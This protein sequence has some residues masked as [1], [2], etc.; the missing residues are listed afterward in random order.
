VSF[1]A[2]TL[3]VASQQ[4]FIVVS[5]YFVIDLVRKILATHSYILKVSASGMGTG[6]TM[7]HILGNF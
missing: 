7:R 1:T 4:M 3:F 6:A 5:V 2:A